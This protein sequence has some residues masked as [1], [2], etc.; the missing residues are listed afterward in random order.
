[1]IGPLGAGKSLMARALLS[2]LPAMMIEESLDAYLF[3]SLREVQEMASDWMEMYNTNRPHDSLG[4][5]SPQNYARQA[6]LQT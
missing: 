4:N 1:M 3:S 5:L 2:I 6:I